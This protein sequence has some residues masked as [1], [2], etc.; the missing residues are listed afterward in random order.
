MTLY[1][2]ADVPQEHRQVARRSAAAPAPFARQKR[3]GR[4]LRVAEG[5]L[6]ETLRAGG[7]PG[8]AVRSC[9]YWTLM[10][11]LEPLKVPR[12]TRPSPAFLLT[13]TS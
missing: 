10:P 2:G 8:R 11:P 4:P 9:G 13:N 12:L 7:S 6:A 1:H 3:Q 5:G